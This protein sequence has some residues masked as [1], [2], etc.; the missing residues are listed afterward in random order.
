M[1]WAWTMLPKELWQTALVMIGNWTVLNSDEI[2][3]LESLVL[4]H[5]ERTA[6]DPAKVPELAGARETAEIPVEPIGMEAALSRAMSL[7]KFEGFQLAWTVRAW[8]ARRTWVGSLTVVVGLWAP[9]MICTELALNYNHSYLLLQNS[10]ENNTYVSTQW[11]AV[12]TQ[13]LLMMEPP[14]NPELLIIKATW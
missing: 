11:A 7:A 5:P 1:C 2:E 3:L 4:P 6:V 8:A 12:N 14:Q 9:A 13:A 10:K